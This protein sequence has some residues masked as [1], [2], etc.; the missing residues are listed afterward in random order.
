MA[1]RSWSRSSAVP[2]PCCVRTRSRSRCSSRAAHNL[3]A[4]DHDDLHSRVDGLQLGLLHVEH[5]E[6]ELPGKGPVSCVRLAGELPALFD[7]ESADFRREESPVLL[8]DKILFEQG[9]KV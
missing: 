8:L 9:T 5:G 1:C 2:P 7:D 4:R 3:L 6:V